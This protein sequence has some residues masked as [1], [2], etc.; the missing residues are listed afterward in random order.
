MIKTIVQINLIF[1]L[2]FLLIFL[3]GCWDTASIEDRGFIVGSAIDI[4]KNSSS[5]LS[6]TNQMV[7]PAGMVYPSQGGGG[8]EAFLNFTSK[9]DSIYKVDE[10]IVS[11][12]SKQ[13]FYE[14][15]AV[16]VISEDVAK[17]EKLFKNLLDTYIRDVDVRR[18]VK[19]VVSKGPAKELLD[20]TTPEDKLPTIHIDKILEHGDK[21]VGAITPVTVGDLEEYHILDVSYVLPYF[22]VKEVVEQKQGAVY[23]GRENKMVGLFTEDEMHGLELMIGK[24]QVSIINFP[25][26]DQPLAIKVIRMHRHM[27]VDPSNLENIKV[28][29]KVEFEGTI[30]ESFMQ[31]ELIDP[32]ELEQIKRA[33]AENVKTNMEKVIEKGQKE[34]GTDVFDVWK[35][36]KTKHY[37]TWVKVKDDWEQGE[38]YFQNVT[39]NIEVSPQIYSIGTMNKTS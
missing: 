28:N 16:L 21:Q 33:V 10:E 12:S 31:H 13:P 30:K 32:K 20:F 3:A 7:L 18:G 29:I 19:V 5:E 34:F 39:F 11:Q 35:E 22:E 8:D 27:T 37:D 25:F 15:L 17:E 26:H 9:S 38:N 23:H 2:C 6:I 36:M 24:Q 14:H 4:E 1:I